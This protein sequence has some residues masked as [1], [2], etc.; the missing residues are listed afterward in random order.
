MSHL[1][2]IAATL[3][4]S[5]RGRRLENAQLTP[6]HFED[7]FLEDHFRGS[8]DWYS[9]T[10]GPSHIKSLVRVGSD[11]DLGRNGTS[12]TFFSSNDDSHDESDLKAMAAPQTSFNSYGSMQDFATCFPAPQWQSISL[13][14]YL[15]KDEGLVPRLAGLDTRHSVAREMLSRWRSPSDFRKLLSGLLVI[16]CCANR[17]V[18]APNLTYVALS[19]VWGRAVGGGEKEDFKTDL[20]GCHL[21]RTVRDAMNVVLV[22][23][24]KYLWV[25]RYCINDTEPG[26]KHR[27]ISNMDAVYEQAYLTIIAA[28]GSDGDH[29][30]PSVSRTVRALTEDNT[31][32]WDG[33]V[34]SRLAGPHLAQ[35][36]NSTWSTRGWTYQEGLLSQRQLVFTD[37]RATF[38]FLYKDH[39]EKAG[40]IFAHIN[41]YS[42]RSLTYPSD[43]L[44]AFLGVFRVHARMWPPVKHAWGVPFRLDIDG[45]IRQPGYG[46]F[47]RASRTCSLRR[48]EGLPSWTWAAWNGW[49]THDIADR[50][51]VPCRY[52]PGP[53]RWLLVKEDPWLGTLDWEPSDISLKVE[54]RSQLTDISDYFRADHGRPRSAE[55]EELAPVLYLT[56]WSTTVNVRISL[57]GCVRFAN[58]DLNT[59]EFTVDPTPESLYNGE[60]LVNGQWSCQWTA[61][62][63]CWGAN[64]GDI[65]HIRTQSLLLD[66]VEDGIFRRVGILETDWH[67]SDLDE[68]ERIDG[69]DRSFAR[70]RFRI[71]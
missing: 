31:P 7:P 26:T 47:W 50:D 24:M 49:S 52:Q 69:L 23:G 33:M 38:R 30:L 42:R 57:T 63:I 25:D 67:K 11:Q 59:A 66:R 58:K 68:Q 56:A 70:K 29:G 18:A 37:N 36:E 10:P 53:Y 13:Q 61:A 15:Q 46:L 51:F 64:H 65:R 14:Y 5:E 45:H 2:A 43:L 39:V 48:I 44:K 8:F 28:S 40:S 3:I 17:V 62:I 1:N 60:P 71:E 55:S 12:A 22:L 9:P 16:D 27:M 4:D 35:F 19:Y 54:V 21:P 41:K 6:S 20:R 34:H 32:P